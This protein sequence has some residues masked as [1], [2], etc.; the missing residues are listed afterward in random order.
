MKLSISV[1][2][3]QLYR[4]VQSEGYNNIDTPSTLQHIELLFMCF[5]NQSLDLKHKYSIFGALEQIMILYKYQEST[6]GAYL[7]NIE[8]VLG[9]VSQLAAQGVENQN[10]DSI[11]SS[12]LLTEVM[13]AVNCN[14]AHALVLAH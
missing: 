9:K 6:P 3:K 12:F 7:K 10:S 8:S 1:Y 14:E 13:F 2:L 4:V 11:K 5:E